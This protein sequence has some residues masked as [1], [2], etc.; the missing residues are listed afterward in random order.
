MIERRR[1][2]MLDQCQNLF[3]GQARQR[4]LGETGVVPAKDPTGGKKQPLA[5]LWRDT[6]DLSQMIHI[7]I[8]EW[9]V[10]IRLDAWDDEAFGNNSACK[11]DRRARSLA[12]RLARIRIDKCIDDSLADR[13]VVASSVR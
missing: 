5:G 11:L 6:P 3:A 9:L 13:H 8:E 1:Q 7:G 4:M 12:R 2:Q 10:R